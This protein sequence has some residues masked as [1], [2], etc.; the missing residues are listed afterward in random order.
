M[1][2]SGAT[3]HITPELTD[4][5]DYHPYNTPQN[6]GTADKNSSAQILGEGMIFLQVKQDENSSHV[7]KIN[8]V[9]YMP[10]ASHRLLSSGQFKL[11]GL[12]EKSDKN[13]TTFLLK[14]GKTQL[15]GLP[16]HNGEPI[17][18]TLTQIVKP[19]IQIAQPT[20]N[21]VDYHT[22]HQ[23]MGHPSKNIIKHTFENTKGFDPKISIPKDIPICTG[24]AQG[25]MQNKSFPISLKRANKPLDLI[26]ADLLKLPIESYHKYKW[27][28]TIL[29]DYSSYA[30]LAFL[31]SKSET[32]QATK[33]FIDLM[34]N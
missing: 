7:I 20:V 17:H 6:I 22:W 12:V 14:S 5:T 25:K 23:R 34:E 26:H 27:C 4:F 3:N 32:F 31:Q 13:K 21:T 24:C 33:S 18:W 30:Y 11:Q 15:I 1:I 2:D 9:C 19:E 16:R 28:L 10:S 29:D 8:N